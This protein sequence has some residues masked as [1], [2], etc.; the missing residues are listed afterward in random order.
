MLRCVL[1]CC[2]DHIQQR[3]HDRS[4]PTAA[5]KSMD[6]SGEKLN[7]AG[8]DDGVD[9]ALSEVDELRPRQSDGEAEAY[10]VSIV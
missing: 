1:K 3:N 6:G 4:Y 8:T 5:A 9:A 2:I 7:N 10:A